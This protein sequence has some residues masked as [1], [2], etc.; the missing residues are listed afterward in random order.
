VRRVRQSGHA[1]ASAHFHHLN[2]LPPN[3]GDVL[4]SFKR[5]LCPEMNSGQLAKVLRA[6]YLIDVETFAK[7]E[8]QPLYVHEI[9]REI[10]ERL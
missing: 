8:G 3:T 10:L 2:P 6:E 9:E 1:I 4:R 7:V 5:V